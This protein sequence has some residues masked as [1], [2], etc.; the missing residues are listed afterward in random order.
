MIMTANG[1]VRR[2]HKVTIVSI[3]ENNVVYETDK[4]INH[5][6]IPDVERSKLLVKLNRFWKLRKCLKEIKPDIVISFWLQPAIFAAILSKPNNFKTIFSERGDPGD[7][8]YNGALGAIRTVA[9]RFMDG[10]VFQTHGAKQYFTDSIQA[11]AVVISNPVYIS[12]VDYPTPPRRRKSIVSVGR[13]HP[14]KNQ[15]LLINAFSKI[16]SLFPEFILEIYGTGNLKND[17]LHQIEELSLKDRIFLKGTTKDLFNEIADAS[18]FVLSSDYEGL[19]NALLEAMALG[20]PSI[21]TDCR[22]GGAKDLI[23]HGINGLICPTGSQ[24]ELAVQIT[25]M[26]QNEQDAER[27]GHEARNVCSTHSPEPILSKWDEFITAI[28]KDQ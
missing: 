27:M 13:L 17:L 14:Q 18:L 2:G 24:E 5:R 3:R 12:R 26:L 19:P 21:S 25:Y 10:F 4:R 16:G 1:L 6:H 28:I 23:R 20:L 8:E 7:K 22:P 9:F 11:K 15:R